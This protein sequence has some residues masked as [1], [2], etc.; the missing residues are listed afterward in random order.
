MFYLSAAFSFFLCLIFPLLIQ[1]HIYFPFQKCLL[2]LFSYQVVSDSSQPYGL[3]QHARLPC[4]SP[5]PEVCPSSCPLNWW[6]PPSISPFVALFSFCLQA[7]PAS[8]S[9]PMK[10]PLHISWPKYCSF[11]FR[12]SPCNEYSGLISFGFDWFDLLSVQGTLRSLLQHH[13]SKVSVLWCLDYTSLCRQCLLFIILSRFVI[14]F[15][16][17]SKGLLIS[18]LQPLSLVILEPK[19]R[20][21]I[22]TSTFSPSICMK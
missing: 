6:C 10:L 22:T 21:Y 13:S 16:P 20:K 3:L 9:F 18:W 11:S 1:K 14:A 8:G 19:K 7:F 17:R 4:F 12:I 2:L 5:S 15:L